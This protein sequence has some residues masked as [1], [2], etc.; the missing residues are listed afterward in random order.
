MENFFAQDG[1]QYLLTLIGTV[2][3]A[4][5]GYIITYRNNL[6]IANRKARL[7]RVNKQLEKLYG[8]LYSLLNASRDA[9]E[10]YVKKHE[11]FHS[12]YEQ[13]KSVP[14][15][16]LKSWRELYRHVFDPINERMYDTI[17]DNADLIIESEMPEPF[18]KLILHILDFKIILRKWETGKE[19]RA[20]ASNDF[21]EEIHEYVERKF[22][23]LK[24]VQHSLLR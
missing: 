14:E 19:T 3:I 15:E 22:K 18:K 4:L 23:Y 6:R 1:N 17:T 11:T 16:E 7:E 13:G 20:L 12:D 5:A 8:P 24:Q 10:D 9:W 2:V 21:P